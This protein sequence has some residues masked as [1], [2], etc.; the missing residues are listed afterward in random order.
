MAGRRHHY[1]PRWAQA[2][3]ADLGAR[4]KAR[5]HLYRHGASAPLLVATRAVGLEGDFYRYKAGA[6]DKS[7]DEPLTAREAHHY[8]KLHHWLLR[9]GP[10]A[11]VS[12]AE[13]SELF[14]HLETRTKE[15]RDYTTTAC[16][17]LASHIK[18]F[19]AEPAQFRA[20]LA[21]L[22]TAQPDV[23]QAA[24][25]S[26][27]SFAPPEQVVALLL[28]DAEYSP[29]E[30]RQIA[31]F[32]RLP[33]VALLVDAVAA[34]HVEAL[35]SSPASEERMRQYADR[36]FSIVDLPD[37]ALVLGSA[38]LI[39]KP[40]GE[41]YTSLLIGG[42]PIEFAFLPLSPTRL[43]LASRPGFALPPW[44]ELRYAS[45]ACSR[46]FFIS[47][48]PSEVLTDLLPKLG[49]WAPRVSD[50][51]TARWI[52][53]ARTETLLADPDGRDP[54]AEEIAMGLVLPHL[55]LKP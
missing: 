28:N 22:V 38:P 50:A 53:E 47:K 13:A 52:Q 36:E 32:S 8:S 51:T 34:G 24:L 26:V 17:R 44:E 41:G 25:A 23:F 55:S 37:A 10:S 30:A 40:E 54:L 29:A 14:A 46:D 5:T 31:Y 12:H 27:G 21:Q 7:A 49:E 9:A 15:F 48:E 6:L 33:W 20:F 45:V 35:L 19:L 42:V 1:V 4:S 16:T 2:G 43:L 18:E 3:F 39:L 11:A